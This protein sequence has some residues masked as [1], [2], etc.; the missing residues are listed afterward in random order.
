[1]QRQKPGTPCAGVLTRNWQPVREVH[2]NP[3][4][5]VDEK[6]E[7]HRQLKKTT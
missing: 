3:E 6:K 2:L 4:Q 1:M 5:R 7:Q